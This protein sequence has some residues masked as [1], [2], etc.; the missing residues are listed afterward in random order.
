MC[1][2][3]RLHVTVAPS[4]S[5]RTRLSPDWLP[6]TLLPWK[7]ADQQ[8]LPV[9]SNW[10]GAAAGAAAAGWYTSMQDSKKQGRV[11]SV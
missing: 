1:M 9:Y 11:E 3:G 4:A 2:Q 10:G 5:K 7:D 6:F 8:L